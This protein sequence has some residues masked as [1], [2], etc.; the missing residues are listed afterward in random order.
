MYIIQEFN[1]TFVFKILKL[2]SPGFGAL[3]FL[4]CTTVILRQQQEI[5][6]TGNGTGI[7]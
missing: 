1:G 2:R 5:T 7:V 4:F 3:G 6:I